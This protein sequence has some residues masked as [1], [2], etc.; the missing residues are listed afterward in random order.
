MWYSWGKNTVIAGLK[1]AEGDSTVER[2]KAK[3][4]GNIPFMRFLALH[5]D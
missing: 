4:T 2:G 1:G 5:A 3:N